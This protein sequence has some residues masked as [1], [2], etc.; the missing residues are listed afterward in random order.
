MNKE[1]IDFM[2]KYVVQKIAV[3]ISGGVDSVA[4]LH[5][6]HEIGA[7]IVA[8]HVNHGLR[9]VADV[10]TEY[11]RDLC[12]R[13]NV[14]VQIFYWDGEKPGSN[15]ESVAREARYKLMTDYCGA[16][17]IEYLSTAHQAYDQ[18]ET[19]LM[20]L[21]RGSGLYGLSAMRAESSRDGIKII[22]P[23][24]SVLRAELAKYC[25]ANKIKYYSD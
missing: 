12:K 8:L 1:F 13:L 17:G 7:N 14:P 21:S 3:A 20:N 15:L 5:W 4:M 19:F 10:E 16:N 18:I 24:L 9:A 23:L 6:L 11:V 25:A 22:R 2:E